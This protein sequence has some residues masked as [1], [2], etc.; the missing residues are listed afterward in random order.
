MTIRTLFNIIL[1][2]IG[3]FLIKDILTTSAQATSQLLFLIL[4]FTKYNVI[5]KVN[6]E[7]I[8]ALLLLFAYGIVFYYL[9][10]KTELIINKLKLEKGFEQK[11]ISSNIHHSTI[12]SISII[13]IGG[14]IL[15]DQIPNFFQQLFLYFNRDST[16]YANLYN[17]YLIRCSVKVIIGL[18][19][20]I[21]QKQIV[22]LIDRHKETKTT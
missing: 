14:L 3:L 1:K 20:I 4:Q 12:L 18:F 13:V 7:L 15:V 19:L 10:F 16:I 21:A 6:L 2:I 11:I 8:P 5:A 22:N 9:V 17:S